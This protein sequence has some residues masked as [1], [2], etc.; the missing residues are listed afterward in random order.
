VNRPP[1]ILALG[2]VLWDLLP[3]GKQLGGAPANFAYHAA[4]LGA[5]A[6]IISAV[7]DDDLGHEILDRLR[8]LELDTSF[9]AIDPDHPTGT[10]T[11]ALE[12]KGQPTYTIHENVAWDF[13]PATDAMLDV[14]ARADCVCFGTLAQR[15]ADSR[16]TIQRLLARALPRALAV[17]DVNLR[18]HYYDWRTIEQ[19]LEAASIVKLNES[20]LAVLNKLWDD[21]PRH[22]REM[23]DTLLGVYQH[24]LIALTRGE[25]GSILFADR[26]TRDEHPGHPP[27]TITDTVGAGDAFTAAL[28]IGLLKG[29]PL[30]KINDDANRLASYVCTEPGATPVI[31]PEVLA[32]TECRITQTLSS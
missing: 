2:E 30:A 26:H 19:S 5:D 28:A 27:S 9:I 11:V 13:I 23:V 12:E 7:G 14:A 16:Q 31:P 22:D 4:Q 1:L 18:Q 8:A 17:F 10:V 3:S 32:A 29:L 24:Q 6:R 15:S 21:R 25:A 20:E